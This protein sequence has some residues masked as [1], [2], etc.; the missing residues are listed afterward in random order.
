MASPDGALRSHGLGPPHSIVLLCLGDQPNAET[1]T[2]QYN[3]TRDRHPCSRRNPSKRAAT[4]IYKWL[5]H[6][7]NTEFLL[8]VEPFSIKYLL[9]NHTV[10]ITIT[11]ANPLKWLAFFQRSNQHSRHYKTVISV[12]T[13]TTQS[14]LPTASFSQNWQQHTVQNVAAKP[15]PLI[16]HAL[17]CKTGNSFQHQ[18]IFRYYVH[19]SNSISLLHVYNGTTKLI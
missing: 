11:H 6:H 15:A 1:S 4:S 8:K 5:Y 16:I 18:Q 12:L 9:N 2:W 3:N 14:V 17:R 13:A 10:Q 7:S 19:I